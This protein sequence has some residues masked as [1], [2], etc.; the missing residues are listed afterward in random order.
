MKFADSSFKTKN[1]IE[2]TTRRRFEE[3]FVTCTLWD[4]PIWMDGGKKVAPIQV[5][6]AP[7]ERG[8]W[9]LQAQPGLRRQ[10]RCISSGIETVGPHASQSAPETVIVSDWNS[11]RCLNTGT[12]ESDE[13][14]CT[15]RYH[16][17]SSRRLVY[18]RR[19]PPGQRCLSLAGAVLPVSGRER[20]TPAQQADA[21]PTWPPDMIMEMCSEC[22]STSSR[23]CAPFLSRTYGSI[24][25]D[26]CPHR[27]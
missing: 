3:N 14:F 11:Y 15:S 18:E 26:H 17:D 21:L 8:A 25:H 16:G 24:L 9:P 13:R 2:R 5:G 27:R 10:S 20:T 1:G 12:R 22:K 7:R 4:I 19:R 23:I 6:A